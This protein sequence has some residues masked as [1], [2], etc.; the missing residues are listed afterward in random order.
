M[1]LNDRKRLILQAIIDDYIDFA[2][3]IGSR[4][5]AKK[6]E[7]G[8]SSA[9]IRNEMSDLE[10]MGY[11][12]QPHTSSGRIPSDKGYRFYVDELMKLKNLTWEEIESIKSIMEIKMDEITQLAKR[13]SFAM[14]K[15]TQYMSMAVS[16]NK[17]HNVL[18]TIQLVPVEGE[19]VLVIIIVKGGIVKNKIINIGK[20]LSQELL[21][22]IS[23]IFTKNLKDCTIENIDSLATTKI[24]NDMGENQSLFDPIF[25]GITDCLISLDNDEI[26]LD[27]T[28]NLFNHPEFEN[29]VKAKELL[30]VMEEKKRLLEILKLTQDNKGVNI[31]IGNENEMIE[32]KNCS[33]ITRSYSIGDATFGMI[34]IIGPTRMEYSKVISSIKYISAKIDHEIKKLTGSQDDL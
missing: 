16:A 22:K 3:P 34:G 12:E 23:K 20:I 5:I 6:H 18:R 9:T 28:V 7:L 11:L 10:D 14:S 24:K 30:K 2:E 15:V 33:I 1:F 8:L 13:A 21:I 25:E 26:F 17:K 4:T 32:I 31:R 27:G 19:R 29:V